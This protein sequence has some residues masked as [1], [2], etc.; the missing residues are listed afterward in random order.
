MVV[1]V[2]A[3]LSACEPVL[4]LDVNT[5]ADGVD[6]LPGNGVCATAGGTCSLRAAITEANASVGFDRITIGTGINPVLSIA[7]AG[8]NANDSGDLDITSNIE[9]LGQGGTIDAAG[10]DRVFHVVAGRLALDEVTVTGG[11]PPATEEGGGFRSEAVLDLRNSTVVGN[12]GGAVVSAGTSLLIADSIITD[13]GSANVRGALLVATG[14]AS[15]VRS[16]IDDALLGVYAYGSSQV[17][18]LDSTVRT[19]HDA[20]N[21]ASNSTGQVLRST[22]QTSGSEWGSFLIDGASADRVHVSGSV[23]DAPM[24]DE[25]HDACWDGVTS[26]GYNVISDDSCGPAGPG[27]VTADAILEPLADNGGPSATMRPHA[28]SPAV[29]LIPAGSRLCSD[30]V[31]LDQRR[32]PRPAGGPGGN[33]DAGAVEAVGSP[34][35]TV[36]LTVDTPSD[37]IDVDPGNGTCATVAGACSLR[38]AVMEANATNPLLPRLA[39]TV[40]IAPGVDPVLTIAGTNEDLAA[41]GDIDITGGLVIQGNGATVDGSGLD[42]VFDHAAPSLDLSDLTVTGGSVVGDGGGIRS[43]VGTIDLAAVTVQGNHA[44]G[45]GGGLSSSRLKGTTVVVADNMAGANGGGISTVFADLSDSTL[46]TNQAAGSGGGAA[47]SQSGAFRRSTIQGNTAA[48]GGGL[49]DPAFNGSSLLVENSTI[50]GNH[51]GGASAVLAYGIFQ[52]G[53]VLTASTINGNT[54]APAIIASASVCTRACMSWPASAVTGSI[55]MGTGVDAA[56]DAPL[57]ASSMFLAP[58]GTCGS[59]LPGTGELGPLA[60]NGGTTLTHLPLLGSGAVDAV[61][62]GTARLCDGSVPTDQRG[63]IRPAGA[64]C[65]V[66]AVEQ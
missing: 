64:A 19:D 43:T 56:C 15:V 55:L 63:S 11:L 46:A 29:G 12:A 34:V 41:T 45:S 30:W 10:L 66:G 20:L 3:G 1:V 23:L 58:D 44:S 38:A 61:P 8:E 7:G 42:R 14:T 65:D 50:S 47:I 52:P 59:S 27:D 17:V 24:A 32:A 25:S 37:G 39:D 4:R 62:T 60:D 51:G 49:A 31:P 16:L 48:L 26:D 35:V 36:T 6:V 40:T 21:F 28:G 33:C 13:N 22:L 57:A 9:I 54:G 53:L 2:V 5:S 18:L